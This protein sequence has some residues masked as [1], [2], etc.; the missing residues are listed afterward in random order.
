M[1]DD[2]KV[3][4]KERKE[5]LELEFN[6]LA[7][8]QEKLIAQWKEINKRLSAIREWQLRIQ[9]SFKEVLD[10]LGEE[11]PEKEEKKK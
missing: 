11:A 1:S 6:S 9:G 10:L 7:E 5:A 8:E 3:K 4:L 2:V